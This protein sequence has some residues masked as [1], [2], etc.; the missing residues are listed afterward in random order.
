LRKALTKKYKARKDL[1]LNTAIKSNLRAFWKIFNQSQVTE[2][3][4]AAEMHEYWK[5]LLG[6]QGIAIR[7]PTSTHQ[8]T[9]LCGDGEEL[10]QEFTATEIAAGISAL[11]ESKAVTGFLEADM[12]KQVAAEAAPANAAL[13]NAIVRQKCMSTTMSTAVI[14]MAMKP[15]ATTTTLNDHRILWERQLAQPWL[16]K[17]IFRKRPKMHSNSFI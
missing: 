10:N 17:V 8:P 6:N 5:Q 11:Q 1:Q 12:L 13:F 15:K 16:K 14:T 7:V 3:H 9:Y 4:S 2:R